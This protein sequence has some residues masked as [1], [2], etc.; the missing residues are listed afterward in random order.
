[1]DLV[2][3]LGR[4][5]HRPVCVA[6]VGPDSPVEADR[7]ALAAECSELGAGAEARLLGRRTQP[8]LAEILRACDAFALASSA[9]GLPNSLLEA[10]AS[11][12]A[13][14]ASE[15]PGSSDVLSGGGGRTYPLRDVDA[16]AGILDEFA[17]DSEAAHALGRAAREIA[18]REY[19]V[20]QVA[21][22]YVDLY[23]EL[24]DAPRA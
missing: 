20:A 7:R 9:E 19:S 2:R 13:S 22:R 8:E 12:L 23:T 5:R 6:L 4:M 18:V 3:A 24:L 1:M 17:G 14:V 21:D 16:L 11:G 10:M 15:V